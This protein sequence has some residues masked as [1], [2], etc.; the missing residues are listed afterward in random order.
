LPT[1]KITLAYDGT[2]YVGW[3]RQRAGMSIQQLLEEA[4]GEL[5]QR[6][7]V[8][9]GAGRTDAGVHA[10]GQVASFS[11]ERVIGADALVRALNGRLPP[12]VRILAAQEV[13]P[14]F[15]A[16]F[17]ARS[18]TYRYRIWNGE[19]LNLFERRYSWHVAATLD[20]GAMA[21]AAVALEGRHD[22]AAFQ[23]T[24]S[25]TRSSERQVTRSIV[26]AGVPGS[27]DLRG[28]SGP[29]AFIVYEITGSGFLRYMVRN[30]VGT[31]VE[32]GRGRRAPEWIHEVLASRDRRQAG[33]TAPAAGLFL[34]V[35]HYSDDPAAADGADQGT[36]LAGD[37]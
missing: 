10:L 18:K 25:W 7:V 27:G 21:R 24:G 36:A 19:V 14:T 15:H 22:F 12:D 4:L 9:I 13:F 28:G 8:V 35:V 33:P 29:G 20:A 5:D 2:H 3:Q 34:T 26:S 32:I 17:Q 6:R 31:L 23:G 11:I 1:F 37:S 16:R 30:I